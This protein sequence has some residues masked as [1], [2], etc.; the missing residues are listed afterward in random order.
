MLTF[1]LAVS[2]LCF[3]HTSPITSAVTGISFFILSTVVGLVT[4]MGWGESA[5][6]VGS[7]EV[8]SSFLIVLW[9]RLRSRLKYASPSTEDG[10]RRLPLARFV[11]AIRRKKMANDSEV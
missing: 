8:E 7:D 5:R 4:W 11:S 2:Y 6:A 10:K 9:N 3:F 1:L